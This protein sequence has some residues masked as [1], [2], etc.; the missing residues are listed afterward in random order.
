[1]ILTQKAIILGAIFLV[2]A[3]YIT[4]ANRPVMKLD[5]T[6][7]AT[8][9]ENAM[10]SNTPT[11]AIGEPNPTAPA[12]ETTKAWNKGDDDEKD[13]E[14]EEEDDAASAPSAAPVAAP[15]P[16]PTTTPPNSWTLAEV[17]THNGAPSCWAAIA[18]SVYDLTEWAGRHPGGS[19]PILG[20]CGTDATTNFER[21][22]GGSSSAKAA[23]A[24][25]KIGTVK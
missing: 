2:G 15:T 4:Y 12:P 6:T 20:M 7:T 1:M 10:V 8:V 23:L 16:K 22:H 25:L 21:K 9:T 14:R 18:G 13:E 3:G 11:I 19:S 5:E 17:A 24:L